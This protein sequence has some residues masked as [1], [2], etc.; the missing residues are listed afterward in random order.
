MNT[1]SAFP[2]FAAW[3]AEVPVRILHNHSTSSPGETKRNIMKAVLRPLAKL[4]A[5]HYFACS[6]LAADWMYGKKLVDEGKVT[7]IHNAIDPDKFAFNPEKRKILRKELGLEGKFV[8]GHVGR[9]MF[10]KN[11]E[12]LIDL[13]AEVVK[14]NPEARLILIGDGPLKEHIQ[15]KV[16]NLGLSEKVQFLGIRNDVAD[17][18]NAMDLFLL[19]SH[20]EGL[21]VVGVEAQA[22]GLPMIVSDRVTKEM[23]V[24]DLVTYKSLDANKIGWIKSV[25]DYILRDQKRTDTYKQMR[26]AGFDINNESNK[27]V[28][29]YEEI[30]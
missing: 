7:I 12:F 19:P 26:S 5:N 20:Y 8:I 17:L 24:T 27:L 23:K 11:H 25:K 13:F 1:L 16:K 22:N 14:E 9:F 18:Y 21:P 15:Q 2:L 4:F 10:Q 6:K 29:I 30:R 3:M 28:Q